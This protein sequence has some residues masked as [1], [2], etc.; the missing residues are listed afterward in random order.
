MTAKL[1][2]ITVVWLALA[3]VLALASPL[4]AQTD[5]ASIVGTVKDQSGGVLPGVTVR[6]T[7]EGTGVTISVVTN[8]A[9][10]Y[11]FPAL[12]IGTYGVAAELQGFKRSSHSGIVLNVQ[13]RVEVDFAL[14]V[15]EV[16]EEVT[17]V[18]TSPLIE[19]QSADMGH[20]VDQRQL[21]DLPLLGRRYAE[22]VFLQTGV[23][24]A[25][26]GI[27]SRGEDTFFSANGNFATWNNFMLDGA[28]NN[29]FS[30]NLQERSL[31]VVQPPVDALE[32]FK[33]QTRSY[34]AEFGKAAGAVVNASIKQ[35]TNRFRG[36]LFE[37]FRDEAFNANTWENNRAGRAK[38]KFNQHI[39]G[40]TL[41]G[42]IAPGKLF[43]F[44]DYQATRSDKTLT[45]LATVPTPLMR[46][47]NFI[48][49]QRAMRT[50]PFIP[51]GCVDPV[52]KTIN[53]SCVDPVAAQL[54]NLY[55]QPNIPQAVARHGIANGFVGPNF[56]SNGVLE[57]PIDQFDVRIDAS[58][59]SRDQLFGRYSFMD[60]TRHE[61]PVLEDPVASGD[62]SSDIFNTGQSFVF[63]WS[64]ILGSSVF[65]ELRA[66]WN[67][68]DSDS[69]HLAFGVDVNSRYGIRGVPQDPRFSGGL[70][71]INIS[72]FTR[73]GGPF[74]R[75][76][77]QTSQVFQVLD[78]LT[79][80]R[81]NHAYKFGFERR[82]DIV[83]YIDLRALNGLLSF[84][85]ARYTNAGLA[86][87]LL[88][89]ASSQGLTLFHE[90]HLFT[91]GWQVFGQ[92]SWRVTSALTLNYGLRYEYFTPMQDRDHI[93]T[94]ID[95]A[96]GE[97]VTARSS[98][99]I[100]D[101]TLI[102][103]DRN[104]VAPRLGFAY[105]M[106]PTAVLR[107]GYGIYYQHTDRYGSESQLG[108]NPPQLIDVNLNANSAA[109]PPVM[110]L[111]NGF[112][113]VSA[114]NVNKAAVQWRIQDPNQKTPIVHQFSVGPELQLGGTMAVSAEYVGNVIRNGRRLR[115]ANQG[116]IEGGRVVFPYA[117]YGFG[118]AFLEQIVTVG[119]A[120]YHALQ[121]KLQRRMSQGL[122]FTVAFT[123]SRARGD[124]LDHL[125]AG[126][127]A[128][129]NFP[130]NAH[131]MRADYG[132]LPFD[133]PRRLVAS[134]IYE[135]PVGEGRRFNPAGLAKAVAGGWSVN[136]ILTLSDGR[137]FTI[138]ANDRSTT[139]PGHQSRAN[140]NG[141]P[142]PGGFNQ[143]IDRWF[144]TAVFSEPA[145][146]TFGNCGYNPV[147]GRGFKTMN[148]SVFRNF[149]MA[150]QRRL[151][152]RIEAFNVF[153]WVNFGFPGGNAS[154][155]ASFGR[156]AGT[157]GDPREMQFAL[158]FYF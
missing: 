17:V 143:T 66:S 151:E 87:F 122:G 45:Q 103:P 95:P 146:L 117:Q 135:L 92:D 99:S 130:Q 53:P 52:A 120:D 18:G 35:G 5:T 23:V 79:W 62:F 82:R 89:L 46:Q 147:R 68:I 155:P 21:T 14:E 85:D 42:P 141:D 10:Q 26:A 78:T 27:T 113:P 55:P 84:S 116:I 101:R 107:G 156:I 154:N 24:Q 124:F 40:G 142:V 28:D 71:H 110:I 30:T 125:S 49:L 61:P 29:S 63:G 152:L 137:P 80:S 37:F 86:D 50:S 94:N 51:A 64:R 74:F 39:A 140:C 127:G 133:I 96:T 57:S 76:Q 111:R 75:P 33:V 32:E 20:E 36:S 54:I 41:G 98:G 11:V 132:P 144:D 158:K 134:F 118:T 138:T 58:A 65:N 73:L 25:P 81:G 34:S 15:G 59:T 106:T 83:D 100:F 157:L 129:G 136:G 105:T 69:I 123:Y 119:R 7:Q 121:A 150:N 9:G 115:N 4:R 109:D 44:A 90:P 77:Y 104:N 70:P 108:L 149:R 22:L 131:D 126:G 8:S 139:G 97:V 38:G 47:G 6:A 67:Q 13:A 2:A 148:L 153:N 114:A 72:G 56:I 60:N 3:F 102:R 128:T 31:Q 12:R 48:E 19:T 145:N 112:A 16:S 93:L 88:G 91:D 1:H 43:F